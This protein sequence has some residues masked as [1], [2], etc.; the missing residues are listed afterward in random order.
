ML[1]YVIV[2]LV[3][4]LSPTFSAMLTALSLSGQLVA[5]MFRPRIDEHVIVRPKSM[6]GQN[7]MAKSDD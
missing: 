5:T 4:M 7:V 3:M 1:L 6:F 2:L